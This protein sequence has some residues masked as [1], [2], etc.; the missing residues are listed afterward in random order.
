MLS[1]WDRRPMSIKTLLASLFVAALCAPLAEARVWTQFDG[2]TLEADLVRA[3]DD[4]VWLKHGG[5]RE[6]V[7]VGQLSPGDQRWVE[8]WQLGREER[9]WTKRWGSETVLG[10]FSTYKDRKVFLKKGRETI[11]VDWDM[12]SPQDRDLVRAILVTRG[13]QHRV[14]SKFD[15]AP[16]SENVYEPDPNAELHVWT[17]VAGDQLQG[18]F[19]SMEKDLRGLQYAMIY[20]PQFDRGMRVYFHELADTDQDYIIRLLNSTSHGSGTRTSQPR[21]SHPRNANRLH[22]PNGPFNTKRNSLNVPLNRE[23]L[24]DP[25]DRPKLR[26]FE[27]NEGWLAQRGNPQGGQWSLEAPSRETKRSSR[28]PLPNKSAKSLEERRH[29]LPRVTSDGTVVVP[30][31]EPEPQFPTGSALNVRRHQ[32]STTTSPEKASGSEADPDAVEPNNLAGTPN[33]PEVEVT[34]TCG[35]CQQSFASSDFQVGDPCPTCGR[36]IHQVFHADG[37]V[38]RSIEFWKPFLWVGA[39]VLIVLSALAYIRFR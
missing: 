9:E 10:R 17:N 34:I 35:A 22:A 36:G 16:D 33:S 2:T 6:K 3:H 11:T 15:N 24:V 18:Q 14:P 32:S 4:E 23:G 12:L 31:H 26:A 37:R 28:G 7:I 25:P 19:E 21:G 30:G 13:Q 29:S 27:A 8:M 5:R 1:L 38:E 20:Q 39:I